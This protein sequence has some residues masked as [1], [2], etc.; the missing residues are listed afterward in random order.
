MTRNANL[1]RGVRRSDGVKNRKPRIKYGSA[2]VPDWASEPR[3]FEWEPNAS[4]AAWLVRY[5]CGVDPFQA[6]HLALS[7]LRVELEVLNKELGGKLRWECDDKGGLGF[8]NVG[9]SL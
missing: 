4:L 7:T 9:P 3:D 8:P 5:V 1:G 6:L 2:P